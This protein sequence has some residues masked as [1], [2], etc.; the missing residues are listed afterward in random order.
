[1][2]VTDEREGMGHPQFGED[3]KAVIKLD[4]PENAAFREDLAADVLQKHILVRL[5]MGFIWLFVTAIMILFTVQITEQFYSAQSNPSSS[6]ILDSPTELPMPTVVVC[7]WNQDGAV[8]AP[9]P[10][11][12]C[13]ECL[14]TLEYCYNWNTSSDCTGD[15]SHTPIQT[16]AGLFDCFTYNAD[17]EN[18]QITNN[19]GYSGSISAVFSIIEFPAAITQRAG[20]QAT[21]KFLD[22]NDTVTPTEI[23]NE[24]NFAPVGFDTFYALRLI[25]TEHLELQPT[26]PNYNKSRF[27][28]TSS[29]TSI[30]VPPMNATDK[31]GY[32]G[33]SFSY[34]TLSKEED[35]FQTGYSLNNLFGDFAGMIGTLMGLD[36]IKVASGLP[37]IWLSI[38]MRNVNPLEDHFNG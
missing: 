2:E 1:M 17:A 21:Y 12:N 10:S 28:S 33:V 37:I 9:Q 3:G 20:C 36:S 7:N 32:V 26:D 16:N 27:S 6:I 19:T 11:H 30:L 34:Q 14:L 35:T 22:P 4:K 29:L 15:W 31:T 13:S 18:P 24:V 23:Y 5:W 8:G 38:R 25:L